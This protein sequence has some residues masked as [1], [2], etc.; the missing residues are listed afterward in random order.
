MLQWR[1]L[2]GLRGYS[3]AALLFFSNDHLS[4]KH[5]VIHITHISTE[6][7]RNGGF[8]LSLKT[9]LRFVG[10]LRGT[11]SQESSCKIR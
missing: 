3:V 11:M 4:V 10:G 5:N 6:R 2:L 9:S 1:R 8:A 7:G